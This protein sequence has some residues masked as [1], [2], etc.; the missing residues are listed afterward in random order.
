MG[1]MNDLFAGLQDQQTIE[2]THT[3]LPPR[4]R[5]LASLERVLLAQHPCQLSFSS[6]KDSSACANLLFTAAISIIAR[7]HTCPPLYVC[8]AD[9]GVENPVVR[10]L[11]DAE[12]AKMRRFAEHHRLPL[13]IHVGRPTLSAAYAPRIIGG[14]ALPPYPG[15]QRDCTQ[16]WKIAVSQRITSAIARGAQADAPPVVTIIGTRASE[17]QARQRNTAAR[18]ESAHQI[19]FSPAGEARLS[20]LLDWSTDEVWEYLGECAAGAHPAY[21]DFADLM[22]FYADA[23]ASSCVVVADMA[24]AAN[25]KACGAR[26]GC[27]ICTAVA[28]DR[29][30]EN[31]I[32]AHPDRY[33]Y[34]VPL[35]AFRDYIAATQWDWARRNFIG[36]TIDADGNIQV[37]ADQ[38]SPAMCEALLR[39]LLAA[40]DRANA[41]GAP[42]PVRAIGLQEL[43][44]IDFYWS[45]RA[46]HPPFHAL[47]VY[48]DHAAGNVQY[49]P[50]IDRPARPSPVPVIGQIHVGKSWDDDAHRLRPPGLRDPAWELFSES[51]G[52]SLRANAA[53]KVFLDLDET[54]EFE[55]DEEGA[56]LF[57][58]FEA[59]DMIKQYHHVHTDWTLAASIYLRYGTVSLAKG[60]SSAIDDMIRRSQWLQRHDLHGH[61]TAAALRPRCT[62]LASAQ[63]ELFA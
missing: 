55:V 62:S 47:W 31:M 13:Q 53:G 25:S 63:S 10:A 24:S 7:G 39:Y 18:K 22:D 2:Q 26:G 54:P 8:N 9:T 29:S 42:A 12:L 3:C 23:G 32:A 41:L 34:L 44:A 58:D 4:E 28:A 19:W 49:A 6:G 61:R 27:F 11:A 36:R 37:K 14:R 50:K 43:I 1:L 20:P 60:Q 5:A 17:S 15:V 38:F 16:D 57:M 45:V 56:A 40:Q 35:L 51:C 21:S 33:A 30:V 59:M 46:W 52:P 48:F